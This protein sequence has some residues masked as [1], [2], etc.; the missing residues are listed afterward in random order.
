MKRL[1]LAVVTFFLL[2]S[3]I[4]GQVDKDWVKFEPEGAGFSVRVPS[5]P[6]EQPSD[7]K[8]LRMF[9]VAVGRAVFAM[10]YADRAPGKTLNVQKVLES[11]RDTFNEKFN[12]KLLTSRNL[13]LEG[14]PGLE[15]TSESP[16]ANIKSRVFL[17]GN[18][19]YQLVCLV[20]RDVD[21]SSSVDI[22]L[23]SFKFSAK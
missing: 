22:F 4:F 8:A 16:A 10:S 2:A 3:S 13:T 9:S 21:M 20:F 15:F 5:K 11:N 7:K 12:A 18:R 23:E 19:E 17:V 1:Y 6:V 14:W